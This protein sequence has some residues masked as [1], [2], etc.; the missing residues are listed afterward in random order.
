MSM[1]GFEHY[2][3]K[4]WLSPSALTNFRR[5]KRYYFYAQGCRLSSPDPAPALEFGKAMHRGFPY[6]VKG[7]VATAMAEF[8]K[9][10]NEEEFADDKRHTEGA[11]RI[12]KDLVERH[13]GNKA[14]YELVKPPDT[15][16]QTDDTSEYEVPFAIDIGAH[17]P[18]F[19]RADGIG[20][21]RD[22]GELWAIEFKTTSQLGSWFIGSFVNN[23]QVLIY[24]LAISTLTGERI[25]GGIIEACKVPKGR[26]KNESMAIPVNVD[27]DQID[28]IL[29]LLYR[30]CLEIKDCEKAE[31]FPKDY[32]A[33]TTYPQFGSPGFRCRYERLC[34]VPDWTIFKDFYNVRDE[35]VELS[36][37]GV[38]KT[39]KLPDKGE[40][41]GTGTD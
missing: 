16:L 39:D 35:P 31:N 11:Y 14:L 40:P 37:G 3:P 19:G 6:A 15:R 30:T 32:T 25:R 41:D 5:C 9:D 33:C 22:T 27:E 28:E 24:T 8:A 29:N 34:S 21:H 1:T 18:V 4:A 20:R 10:W 17:I 2:K 26:G 13:S 7:D 36:V 38:V 23:P 12:F